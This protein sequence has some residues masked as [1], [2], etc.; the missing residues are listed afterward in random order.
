MKTRLYG[1]V[2]DNL[3]A[4]QQI[5]LNRGIPLDQQERWLRASPAEQYDWTD[6][7]PEKMISACQRLCNYIT[8]NQPIVVIIDCDCD[9]FS[10][11]AILLNYLHSRYPEYDNITFKLH[12]GKQHGLADMIDEIPDDTAMVICPDS[13]SN[14]IEQHRILVGKHMDVLCLDHHDCDIDINDSPATI[15][16]VQT[17]TYP[18][19]QL[20][21]SG[22]TYKFIQAYEDTILKG[23]SPDEFCDLACLGA[24]GDMALSTELEIRSLVLEGLSNIHNDFFRELCEAHS[25]VIEK[26]N[27][28]NY[29]SIAFSVVP[30]INSTNRSGTM[31]E[32]E[33][34]FRA[35]LD[36]YSHQ[37]V[38]S[39]KRGHKGEECYWYEEAVTV[40]ERIK[41]RQSDIQKAEEHICEEKIAENDLLDEPVLF[42]QLEPDEGESSINGLAGNALSAKYQKP[43]IVTV[44][45]ETNEGVSWSGS[46]R[47]YDKSPIEDFRQVINDTGLAVAQGHAGASGFAIKDEDVPAFMKKMEEVYSNVD[48]T[49]TYWIDYDWSEGNAD[50]KKIL[51]IAHLNIYGQG[52]QESKV[53][54]HG[55]DLS[56]CKIQLLGKFLNT[57]K[58]ELPNGVSVMK[59][60]TDKDFFDSLQGGDLIMDVVGK[61]SDNQWN[62]S[63]YPQIIMEDCDIREGFVF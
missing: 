26:R 53:E 23:D 61:P 62:G 18:D 17:C 63:H 49:P 1:E 3:T 40:A 34:I 32:K 16:N 27:G 6:L 47:N 51:D 48:Q 50:Q 21:G 45:Q 25:Y 56:T 24:I 31:E 30:W 5:L 4:E 41:R 36:K 2:D 15:I 13:A 44:R 29:N 46:M 58:I 55:I 9:G 42:L 37:L 57:V 60:Q 7:E 10:S 52:I 12:K 43:T 35:M 39:S 20:T 22:V 28:L 59:F 38:P 19:K 11:G 33:F 54:I 14:D 8:Y